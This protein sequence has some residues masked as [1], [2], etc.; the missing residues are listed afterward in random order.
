MQIQ[1]LRREIEKDEIAPEKVD[2]LSEISYGE[3]SG[4]ETVTKQGCD[5]DSYPGGTPDDPIKNSIHQRLTEIM[6]EGTKG[7]IP[8]LRCKDI[9][10]VAKHVNEVN[11][12]LKCITSKKFV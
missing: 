7:D 5:S 9:N 11:E 1:Q 3:S 10:F 12:V 2:T 4:T 6:Y 8:T